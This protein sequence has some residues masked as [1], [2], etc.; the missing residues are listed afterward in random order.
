MR[1]S[2]KIFGKA[3][4]FTQTE[5]IYSY[6]VVVKAG[7]NFKEI[8]WKEKGKRIEIKMPSIHVTD[9]YIDEKSGKVYCEEESIFSPVTFKENMQAKTKLVKRGVDDAIAN[10]LYRNAKKNAEVI[11]KS[12]FRQ[13]AEYKDHK[14]V[15]K[16][17]KDKK[18]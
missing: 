18:I 9:S 7:L 10:G 1:D 11:L 12:F 5:Y 8:V 15:F 4:P 2:R 13:H 3:V 16:W 14:I 6:N 17:E